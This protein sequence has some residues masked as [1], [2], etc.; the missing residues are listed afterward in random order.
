[1]PGRD[2]RTERRAQ[3][4]ATSCSQARPRPRF[5]RIGE[6]NQRP[7]LTHDP[8]APNPGGR[9]RHARSGERMRE[10]ASDDRG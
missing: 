4:K 5:E 6:A 9:G 2:S 8:A 7:V 3:P 10:G 1:M